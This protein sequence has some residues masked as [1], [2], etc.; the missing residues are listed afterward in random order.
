MELEENRHTINQIMNKMDEMVEAW[1]R[2]VTCIVNRLVPLEHFTL[3][4]AQ[5]QTHINTV[6]TVTKASGSI[7]KL[8]ISHKIHIDEGLNNVQSTTSCNVKVIIRG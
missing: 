8:K 6:Q 3:A 7:K 5:T 4:Y 1:Q 2:S